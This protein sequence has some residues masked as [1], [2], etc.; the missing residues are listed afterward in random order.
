[1]VVFIN[2][3]KSQSCNSDVNGHCFGRDPEFYSTWYQDKEIHKI[4]YDNAIPNYLSD[5]NGLCD[6]S[7]YD[8][9]RI[10]AYSSNSG[11]WMMVWEDDFIIT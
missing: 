11:D 7:Y 3:L 1:M 6:E 2:V 9:L 10:T 4:G 5:G 8:F